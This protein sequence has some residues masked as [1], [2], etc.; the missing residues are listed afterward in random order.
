METTRRR[1]RRS[2][3]QGPPP[4]P[5]TPSWG[6]M[7]CSIPCCP[8]P[9][10]SARRRRE[11]YQFGCFDGKDHFAVS[12]P[13]VKVSDDHNRWVHLAG[14]YD[15][16]SWRVYR[17]GTQV[18]ELLDA[19]Q[20]TVPASAGWAIGGSFDGTRLF[21][22]SIGEVQV[23]AA[24]R[25]PQ[26]LADAA[27]AP[28]W[29]TGT[30]PGLA[31]CVR[32]DGQSL[33]DVT[34]ARRVVDIIGS[35]AAVDG[36]GGAY[37][38]VAGTGPQYVESSAPFPGH[39]WTHLALAFE[40]D[41]AVHLSPTGYLDAGS[42]DTLDITADLTLRGHRRRWTTWTRPHGLLTAGGLPRGAH[43]PGPL[44]PARRARRHARLPVRRR[45]RRR[46]RPDR[47]GA[48][49]TP[50]RLY[51]IGVVR[52]VNAAPDPQHPT[53]V[54]RWTDITFVVD[55]AVVVKRTYS[56]PDAGSATGPLHLGRVYGADGAVVPLRG[57][58]TEARLWRKALDLGAVGARI[59]GSESGSGRVVAARRGPRQ[60]DRGREGHRPGDA[61]GRRLLGED[62]GPD[63]F[64]VQVYRDGVPVAT[65]PVPA[66]AYAPTSDGFMLGGTGT[67][68]FTGQLEELRIWRTRRTTEQ[69]QDNLFRRIEGEQ[70]DLVAYYTFDGE[71][72]ARLTDQGP[73][74]NTLAVV[75]GTTSPRPRRSGRT[76]P[77]CATPSPASPT[78]TPHGWPTRRA[79]PST[80]TCSARPT[81]PLGVY[82]RCY[83]LA[84][85][86]G[87][88]Q[89]ITGLQGGRPGRRVGGA[90]PVRPPA[91]RV[92]RRRTAGAQREPHRQR[93]RLRRGQLGDDHRG[94]EDQV[95]LL[96]LPHGGHRRLP[97]GLGEDLGEVNDPRGPRLRRDGDR[98]TAGGRGGGGRA[99]AQP[100]R[101]RAVEHG[102]RGLALH[103]GL[104]LLAREQRERRGRHADPG[105]LDGADRPTGAA[106]R[107]AEPGHR[108]PV[109]AREPGD[110]AG[111]VA[112]RRRVRAAA[113]RDGRARGVPDA[114]QP[115]HPR[116]LEHRDLPDQ[117]PLHQAGR[118]RR[119][120]PVGFQNSGRVADQR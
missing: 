67:D 59:N 31:L 100:G 95:H 106:E 94:L 82:K 75:A 45:R 18:G 34:P 48:V 116:R 10:G 69:L 51:R 35:P 8:A 13:E 103:R 112:D 110:G 14:V 58:L 33:I 84:D 24:A 96:Q 12:G 61:A 73:R 42:K 38:V 55:G 119:Q 15:G 9:R 7:T 26:Q 93:R 88:W 98:G 49:S 46:Q 3:S 90:G 107:P 117:P 120:G 60:H 83:A 54:T 65:T 113:A 109:G 21:A 78:S 89:L 52:K 97:R 56:G 64:P 91:R 70:S 80:P 36:L 76:P 101:D 115:R 62:P 27:R 72:G 104:D 87:R 17:N 57:T 81:A 92:H 79:S 43:R 86:A 44:L 37:H 114:G 108:S 30:E 40:Q 63:R 1:C 50:G 5:P 11:Q 74:G 29:A 118:A 47:P 16:T 85:D 105:Q 23:W 71:P 68:R 53:T 111:A 28:R 39:D 77:R 4:L 25:T 19:A 2:P 99:V 6:R 66:A 41:Y 20:A 102:R 32:H 22:G